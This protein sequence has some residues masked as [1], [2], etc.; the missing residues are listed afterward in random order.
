MRISV[1]TPSFNQ[2]SYLPRMLA[3]INKQDL[4]PCEH[5]IFDAGSSDG[6]RNILEE[7][8]REMKYA[9]LRVAKDRGPADA[10]NN[11]LA[12]SSGD[13]LTWLNTDDGYLA[14]D[15]LK[16]VASFFE[17]NSEIDVVYGRGYFVNSYGRRIK[18]FWVQ[19]SADDLKNTLICSVGIAQPTV[20]FRRRAYEQIGTLDLSFPYAFDYDYWIRMTRKGLK[21]AFIN[22]NIAYATL[23]DEGITASCRIE[24]LDQSMK[25]VR[26]HFGF[27]SSEWVER[28]V[29]RKYYDLDN[30]FQ[31]T[32]NKSIRESEAFREIF[33]DIFL[34][35][36]ESS[37]S[38]SKIVLFGQ[39]DS[40]QS[41]RQQ[42]QSCKL[43]NPDRVLLTAVNNLFYDS[44]LTLIASV[45][46]H[47]VENV[48]IFVYDLGLSSGQRQR[49]SG[50]SYVFVLDY[51][52]E[53]GSF[54]DG[55]LDPDNYGFKS[56]A[57]H[58]IVNYV[59]QGSLVLY[60]DAGIVFL[61]S[62]DKVF[63]I[64][65]Q[66][67]VFF[68][69]HDDKRGW[70]FYNI[71]F[72]HHRALTRMSATA[73]EMLSEHC[74]GG[75]AGY[76]VGGR[77]QSLFDE[78]YSYSQD[79]EIL[80]WEKHPSKSDPLVTTRLV[81]NP[82]PDRVLQIREGVK[83]DP[84]EGSFEALSQY[85][86]YRGHRHNQ[87]ILSIL[88]ARYGV[89]TQS[90]RRFCFSNDQS[91]EAFKKN[92]AG[93]QIAATREFPENLGAETLTFNHR[94]NYINH[95]R[96]RF[97][98]GTSDSLIVLGNGPS[99]KGFD[100]RRLDG[101]DVIG[102]NVA[103]RYWERIGWF[104][105]YYACL[106]TVVGISHKENIARLIRE[107]HINGIRYFVL[108]RNLVDSISDAVDHPRVLVFEDMQERFSLLSGRKFITTGSHAALIGAT[109]GYRKIYLLGVDC[110]YVEQV[111]G[112]KQVGKYVLE[113]TDQS[114]E[115][116]NYFFEDY[117]K[118]GDRY[119]IPNSSRP[120]LHMISWARAGERLE[121]IGVRVINANP[122][123]KLDV[124]PFCDFKEI[125]RIVTGP[126][127][128]G[129]R[130]H[131]DETSIV[132]YLL[133]ESP[134]GSIMVDVGAHHG[135]ALSSFLGR[136]WRVVAFEPD[137]DNRTRLQDN[138][139]T[140]RLLTVD[141]RALSDKARAHAAFYTSEESSGIGTLTPFTD[142]HER[143]ATIAVTTMD[144]VVKEYDLSTI[145]FLKID[146]E[147]YDLMV[148]KGL[149]WEKV[150][151]RI[152][153]CEFE[154]RKT[155]PLGY[156]FHDLAGLL[157]EKGYSVFVSEWHPIVRYG[158][159]HD[160]RCLVRYPCKLASPDAWGNLIAF[161]AAPDLQAVTAAARRYLQAT[162][163]ANHSS[164]ADRLPKPWEAKT[165]PPRTETTMNWRTGE[166][167]AKVRGTARRQDARNARFWTLGSRL[168]RACRHQPI[169][170]LAM[171]RLA[172]PTS[173]F[174][175]GGLAL[176]GAAIFDV[177]WS[178]WLAAPGLALI[179]L[180]VMKESILWRWRR[181]RDLKVL[182]EAIGSE[183]SRVER[184]LADERGRAEKALA[185]ER[186]RAEKALAA[187]LADERGRAEKALADERGRAEKALAAALADE[188]G[189]AEKAL[190]AAVADE[191]NGRSL[192]DVHLANREL[193]L[194]RVL[195][196]FTIPRSG[197]T[198]LF[199]ILRTHP[200]VRVEPTARVWTALDMH[201][202]RYPAAFHH[203]DGAS[204]PLEIAP[205]RAAAIPAFPQ[206][207]LPDVHLIDEIDRWALEKAHP[208]F[209]EFDARRLTSRIQDLRRD[210][211]EVEVVYGL[212]NPL[213]SMWS[214]VEYKARD[215]EWLKT[216]QVDEVPRFVARSLATLSDLHALVGGVVVEYEN[217]PDGTVMGSLCQRLV[218]EWGEAEARAW[219]SHAASATDRYKRR[220][221]PESSFLGERNRSRDPAG[222]D[223]AWATADADIEAA[224]AAHRRLVAES[225]EKPASV[226]QEKAP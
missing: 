209:V 58:D 206:A 210:G 121:E 107:S 178:A 120:D 180:V 34:D 113:I 176:T 7:Y 219:I 196:L 201:G 26:K 191:R 135:G 212:R 216:L 89:K 221:L 33:D 154:D 195:L 108:L 40:V 37:E 170:S 137:P 103:Y 146:T 187:A 83:R 166:A 105:R 97:N 171:K 5:L 94:G 223:G 213:A 215:P 91:S 226:P 53:T 168:V 39:N 217:L 47:T 143:S 15:T 203:V 9:I 147:G 126:Y 106:D 68:T 66:E 164:E 100:F 112:S 174:L 144:R 194:K 189:R 56:A 72:T 27:V 123:S 20:F 225:E 78:A 64:I 65:S 193:P 95:D 145:D 55:Y 43:F 214:M 46:R 74:R 133:T 173:A 124:F 132:A 136:G 185:D 208:S 125:E 75:F 131:I 151:P 54:F 111:P 207:T 159:R 38:I 10:I 177:V 117:Q 175:L 32:N 14:A 186:G 139:G 181:E 122:V 30:L 165:V 162:P 202:L 77:Y 79:P 11:G 134:A 204:V 200:A 17:K 167:A 41:T 45:H 188:R 218:S 140:S 76:K 160:W 119:H 96:I 18:P 44:V 28:F 8:S 101:F 84:N 115:N 69:N 80:C 192:V 93:E 19:N 52:V 138:Y 148:L 128:R 82:T 129:E 153:L 13:V 50:F 190:A 116:P 98:C 63:D 222:P 71:T 16:I 205:S 57:M 86:P 110:N 48:P 42:L 156:G 99:L 29:L 172:S 127:T 23:H 59:E 224:K 4:L 92:M 157:T 88:V 90:A 21:F 150:K 22:E 6:S 149:P 182:M 220:W 118:K 163:E 67:D 161:R 142:G 109:F 73:Q 155:K 1:I 198:W 81:P 102:M 184:V 85:F 179:G 197:S 114:K 51:P 12:S 36:N 104:P 25:I 70:P 35:Q 183:R 211:T 141:G 152:I 49:L 31:N 62:P 199:D 61:Q 169:R 158:I 60:C 3:S 87:S 130:A 2:A 24:Q